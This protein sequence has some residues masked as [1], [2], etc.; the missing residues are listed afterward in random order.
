[1]VRRTR[2]HVSILSL[3]PRNEHVF[4]AEVELPHAYALMR[5]FR[6]T[7]TGT[8]AHDRKQ[9]RGHVFARWQE[10]IG[11]NSQQELVRLHIRK[12]ASFFQ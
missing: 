9:E 12:S 4:V 11:R 10:S 5:R 6:C 8:E 1:M 2:N 3:G 7:G